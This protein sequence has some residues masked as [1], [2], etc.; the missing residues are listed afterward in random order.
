EPGRAAVAPELQRVRS[1]LVAVAVEQRA[2]RV[3]E[4]DVARGARAGELVGAVLAER[5]AGRAHAFDVLLAVEG[6]VRLQDEQREVGRRAAAVGREDGLPGPVGL[7][8]E[9]FTVAGGVL[10]GRAVRR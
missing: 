10:R 9:V 1:R 2:A 6:V 7:A 5:V 3:V 8:F 4:A